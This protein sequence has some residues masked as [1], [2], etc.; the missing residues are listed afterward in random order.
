MLICIKQI[1]FIIPFLLKLLQ[2]NS[3]L[4]ILGKLGMPRHTLNDSINLKKSLM[5]ICKQ[6]TTSFIPFFLR[7]CKDIRYFGNACILSQSTQDK[8][9]LNTLGKPAYR[10]P[11]WYQH[12]LENFRIY[13]QAKEQLHPHCFSRDIAKICKFPILGT[14]GMS[15]CAHPNST[16]RYFFLFSACQK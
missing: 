15:G 5:F 4:V 10:H 14:L 16:C 11:Q 9:I 12:L 2:R 7:Y 8:D 1:N 3:K 13:L 6:K